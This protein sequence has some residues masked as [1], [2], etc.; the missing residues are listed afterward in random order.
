MGARYAAVDSEEELFLSAAHRGLDRAYRLAGLIL[1]S[2]DEAADVTH[3]ALIKAWHAR[4]SLRDADRF[5]AWFDRILVNLCR[6]RQR[7]AGR[8]QFLPID[9]ASLSITAA[10]PF[11]AVLDADELGRAIVEL[12]ADA[13]ALVILRYWA[14][15]TIDDV[16]VRLNLPAGT[17]KS[18][19]HRA[20]GQLRERLSVDGQEA[21]T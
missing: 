3:E 16:A 1:G 14:D 9:G 7:R 15:L 4:S 17:V 8:V 18:R 2:A 12:D 19:L 10:D 6:D 20:L 11:R 21:G 5:S 13:R